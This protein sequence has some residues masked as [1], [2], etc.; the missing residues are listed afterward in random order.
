MLRRDFGLALYRR[1]IKLLFPNFYSPVNYQ[2]PARR[3]P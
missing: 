3:R 1:E 2:P